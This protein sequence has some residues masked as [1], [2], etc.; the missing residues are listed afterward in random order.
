MANYSVRL[1]KTK[2]GGVFRVLTTLHGRRAITLEI[3][4]VLLG[5]HD[6]CARTVEL[7]RGRKT[8]AI[9]ARIEL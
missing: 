8:G 1:L 7:R 5:A 6:M 3:Q 2:V 4:R 9:Y